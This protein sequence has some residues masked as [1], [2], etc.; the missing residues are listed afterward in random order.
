MSTHPPATAPKYVT[1]PE[2]SIYCSLSVK[3]LRRMVERGELA[4]YRP[5]RTILISLDDLDAFLAKSRIEAIDVAE[6]AALAVR[7]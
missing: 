7:S 4:H 1:L 3:T 5:C 6:L 2:A